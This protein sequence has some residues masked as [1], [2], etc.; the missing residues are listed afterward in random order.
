MLGKSLARSLE[1]SL[2]ER[3]GRRV[4]RLRMD[5][6]WTL[7]ELARRLSAETGG[8]WDA[9]SVERMEAGVY[10][11]RLSDIVAAAMAFGMAPEAFLHNLVEER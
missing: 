8:V 10:P 11:F 5:R 7:L 1:S 2:S 3:V 6:G 4:R 9:L